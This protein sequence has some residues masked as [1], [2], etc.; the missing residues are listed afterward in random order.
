MQCARILARSDG[1]FVS[2][3]KIDPTMG[4]DPSDIDELAYVLSMVAKSALDHTHYHHNMPGKGRANVLKP[5]QIL[6]VP[7]VQIAARGWKT[8]FALRTLDDET[9]AGLRALPIAPSVPPNQALSE[10]RQRYLRVDNTVSFRIR[11]H[12]S[13][14]SKSLNIAGK[15]INLLGGL[16]VSIAFCL[17][18]FGSISIDIRGIYSIFGISIFSATALYFFQIVTRWDIPV[19]RLLRTA[20]GFFISAD[21]INKVTGSI[22]HPAPPPYTVDDFGGIIANHQSRLEGEQHRVSMHQAWLALAIGAA[23][24][25]AAL[26]A[27]SHPTAVHSQDTK[28]HIY[29]L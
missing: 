11:L 5:S 2:E 26:S 21:N 14:Q 25:I 24:L 1:L 29:R 13:T 28:A 27:L 23:S 15:A 16:I 6:L 18:L 22:R 10:L 8:R 17:L 7:P 9:V 19:I 3:I 4:F 12:R 20:H